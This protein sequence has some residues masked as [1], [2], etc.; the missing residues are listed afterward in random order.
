MRTC[1]HVISFNGYYF[2]SKFWTRCN[3]KATWRVRGHGIFNVTYDHFYCEGHYQEHISTYKAE[4]G[5]VI[6]LDENPN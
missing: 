1:Q 5:D 6:R 4:P 3:Q 2:R